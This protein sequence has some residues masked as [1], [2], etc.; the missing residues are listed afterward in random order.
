[1]KSNKK[2]N[3]GLTRRQEQVLPLLLA[4]P[5]IEEVAREAKISS[6][7]I[8]EWMKDEFFKKAI[9]MQRDEIFSL[10]IERLKGAASKAVTTLI[11]LL[12]DENSRIRLSAADKILDHAFHGLEF[13]E[14]EGKIIALEERIEKAVKDR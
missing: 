14:L 12:E 11:S 7:Q 13:L 9:N 10:S 1:M 2:N 5:C 4:N 3:I 8:H 6:K